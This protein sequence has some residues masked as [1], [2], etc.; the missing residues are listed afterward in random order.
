MNTLQNHQRKCSRK[1]SRLKLHNYALYCRG[2]S[3][4][5]TSSTSLRPGIVIEFDSGHRASFE[6]H[7]VVGSIQRFTEEQAAGPS[8]S[9]SLDASQ[10]LH[11]P[12][13]PTIPISIRDE[14][15]RS[16]TNAQPSTPQSLPHSTLHLLSQSLLLLPPLLLTRRILNSLTAAVIDYFRGRYFRTTFT[17]LE[18]LYLRYYEFPAVTRATMRV[19]AQL[20]ILGG[21]EWGVRWWIGGILG[22]GRGLS[23][24]VG[25][26]SGGIGR[27]KT[28]EWDWNGYLPC[29]KVGKGVP[30]L[31]GVVW[32][33]AVVGAG[34]ACA[35]AVSG[36]GVIVM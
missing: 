8:L 19:V 12:N 1:R 28:V 13:Q 15:T 29:C 36:N 17:R 4:D 14:A 34:H 24:F 3:I 18:R 30:W 20:G 26:S 11:R 10:C 33:G 9:I 16:T 31:C 35:M 32:I 5:A 6:P 27:G 7:S 23:S 21:L 25:S 2:G 22:E